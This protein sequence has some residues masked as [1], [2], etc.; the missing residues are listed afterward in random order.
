MGGVLLFAGEDQRSEEAEKTDLTVPPCEDA[1]GARG[2]A[3]MHAGLA[4]A[5][6]RIARAEGCLSP[7]LER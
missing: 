5:G 2:R 7:Q 1:R 6:V 4:G 3:K